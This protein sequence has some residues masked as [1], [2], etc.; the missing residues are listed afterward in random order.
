TRLRPGP[1]SERLSLWTRSTF[2]RPRESVDSFHLSRHLPRGVCVPGG[3]VL[4]RDEGEQQA[5][6]GVRDEAHRDARGHGVD[7]G[8]PVKTW[9]R[10]EEMK[11]FLVA[12]V[13][14]TA[15]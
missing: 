5:H 9:R 8:I 2:W 14:L 6:E 11:K 4:V 15:M 12:M 13:L 7:Q 10:E 3:R 1:P